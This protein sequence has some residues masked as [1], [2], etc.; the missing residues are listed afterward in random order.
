M[1][2]PVA[3][4]SVVDSE[5]GGFGV[6]RE[7]FS[8]RDGPPVDLG[9]IASDS[10]EDIRSVDFFSFP[11]WLSTGFPSTVISRT[12]SCGEREGE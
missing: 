8:A 12:S 7:I 10:P 6:P 1:P 3:G 2:T 11:G 9:A 4:R 5:T